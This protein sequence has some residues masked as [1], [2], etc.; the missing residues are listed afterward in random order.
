MEPISI[1]SCMPQHTQ[2]GNHLFRPFITSR[3]HRG[4]LVVGR[5]SN[6]IQF[7]RYAQLHYPI[8]AQMRSGHTRKPKR[9]CIVDSDTLKENC[10]CI[11]SMIELEQTSLLEAVNKLLALHRQLDQ[12]TEGRGNCL[13][14]QLQQK[15]ADCV[16]GL[17][18]P[19]AAGCSTQRHASLMLHALRCTTVHFAPAAGHQHAAAPKAAAIVADTFGPGRS[20]HLAAHS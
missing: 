5:D 9:D 3:P 13:S 18:W 15:L 17:A 4:P 6:S 7:E 20:G 8:S 16:T 10:V 14:P 11:Q 1:I 2:H 12:G 19:C